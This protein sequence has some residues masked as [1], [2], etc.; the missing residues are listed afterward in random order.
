[1]KRLLTLMAFGV[2]SF[3]LQA[4]IP[5]NGFETLNADNNVSQ[6]S[7]SFLTVIWID[8]TGESHGDSIVFDSPN[9]AL[10]LPTTDAHSGQYALEMRN[11][12]NVTSNVGIAG[13]AFLSGTDT[14]DIGFVTSIPVSPILPETFS[15]YYKYFPLASDSAQA[16][17]TMYDSDGIQIGEA[18]L[19]L[20][21]TVSNYTLASASIVY[22]E[23]RPVENIAIAFA[24]AT[25]GNEPTF[26]TRFIVDDVSLDGSLGLNEQKNSFSLFPNPANSNFV[27]DGLT[28]NESFSLFHVSG[29]QV[30]VNLNQS[31]K[32]DC[33][34]W[35]G[36][37]YFLHVSNESGTTV[38]KLIVSH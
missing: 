35:P 24:T 36:G 7:K 21:G 10:Y 3:S 1:M 29:E 20:G 38:K 31:G 9:H 18:V 23:V 37:V 8:S 33:S 27:I 32:I 30:D 17:A 15:F 19:T 4:Q 13:G 26:G 34:S 6:W 28:G 14:Y 22:S 11:A 2:L 5:N 12:F 25:P 16:I